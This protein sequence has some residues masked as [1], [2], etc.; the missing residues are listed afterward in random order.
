LA[1]KNEN[2]VQRAPRNPFV[3]GKQLTTKEKGKTMNPLTHIKKI[4]ILPLLSLGAICALVTAAHAQN[5]NLYVSANAPGSHKIFEFTPSGAQSIYASGLDNPRGLAFDSLGNLFATT[6]HEADDIEIGKVL[7]FNLRNHVSNAG[8][9]AK[10]FFEGLA[11]DIAGNAYVMANDDA[12][13]TGASTI[14]KLTPSGARIV[15][16]S[17]PTQGWGLAFDSGGNLYAAQGPVNFGGDPTIYKFAPNGTRTIF[18]GPNAFAPGEYPVGLAFDSSGNLYV[19]IETFSDPGADSIVYFT[20][21]GA[22]NPFASGLTFPRGLAF[23]GSGNLFVA[24][25]NA[26]PAGD[27]LK[28]PSGG[29]SPTVFASGFGRPEFLTFGPSR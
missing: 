28:F 10:F 2:S 15:F 12:S 14:F 29:G 20:P 9:A 23:D 1:E 4:L 7:K 19:S 22:R 6:A 25:A 11:T 8:S 21:M 13:P 18:A 3:K 24:E 26:I 17:L 27:I 5:L 16:G